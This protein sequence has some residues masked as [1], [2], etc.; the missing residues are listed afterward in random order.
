[1]KLLGTKHPKG[2]PFDPPTKLKKLSAYVLF[3]DCQIAH[4]KKGTNE[5]VGRGTR[6][7]TNSQGDLRQ[8]RNV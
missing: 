7:S 5:W 4:L 3:W 1:M 2:K 8:P 6:E